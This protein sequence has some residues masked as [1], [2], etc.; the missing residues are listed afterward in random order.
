[1]AIMVIG[2]III[3]VVI[4]VIMNEESIHL[5]AAVSAIVTILFFVVIGSIQ[6]NKNKNMVNNKATK[7]KPANNDQ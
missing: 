7:Q 6:K 3:N 2:I 5:R 4:F 1:M